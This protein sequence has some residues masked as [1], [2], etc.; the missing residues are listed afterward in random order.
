[1]ESNSLK[2]TCLEAFN[3]NQI[4]LIAAGKINVLL[5]AMVE[6]I[7]VCFNDEDE[8]VD[9]IVELIIGNPL[10]KA[11]LI[12]N[13]LVSKGCFFNVLV[14]YNLLTKQQFNIINDTFLLD[15]NLVFSGIF[16]AACLLDEMEWEEFKNVFVEMFSLYINIVDNYLTRNMFDSIFLFAKVDESSGEEKMVYLD[17][18]LQS[19][20]N[21]ISNNSLNS[22][23]SIKEKLLK[24]LERL[25]ELRLSL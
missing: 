8:V 4:A 12:F 22:Q 3:E 1:M 7:K 16:I 5:N 17:D 2:Y 24:I 9:G 23:Y 15:N 21:S 20:L 14:E 13:N 25:N 18:D 19:N 6:R 11:T 10:E